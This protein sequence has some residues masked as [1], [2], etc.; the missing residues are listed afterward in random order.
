[1]PLVDIVCPM[2]GEPCRHCS[3]HTESRPYTKIKKST[4]GKFYEPVGLGKTI[5]T[6]GEFCNNDGTHLVQDMHYC[7]ARWAL[8]RGIVPK[9]LKVKRGRP[10]NSL[11]KT[12]QTKKVG[13]PKKNDTRKIRKGQLRTV[14]KK[15]QRAATVPMVRTEKR[16]YTRRTG[17]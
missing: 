8:H 11:G 4:V 7:P 16:K 9:V 2:F 6:I 15:T 10:K 1:M 17:T 13:R 12:K 3:V 5:V 14:Q